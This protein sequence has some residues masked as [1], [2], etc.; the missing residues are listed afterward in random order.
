MPLTLLA[1]VLIAPPTDPETAPPPRAV[2]GA[3]EVRPDR[4]TARPD[5]QPGPVAQT[6]PAPDAPLVTRERAA[7]IAA[8]LAGLCVLVT[9][10]VGTLRHRVRRQTEQIR[11]Q[12]E[13][14]AALEA[15][16][17]DLFE[18]AGDAVWV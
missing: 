7:L 12:L 6:A 8:A 15:R 4:P 16:Y 13:H 1:L 9:V 11:R 17:R 14:E 2:A 18:G 5:G 3:V 10:W